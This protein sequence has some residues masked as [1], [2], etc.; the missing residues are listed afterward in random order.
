VR[1][2]LRRGG[3]GPAAELNALVGA[4]PGVRVVPMFGRWAYLAGGELF[5]CFPLRARD[6][7]LWIRL[8]PSA[9]ARA[10]AVP[11]VR[12]H[13]RFGRRG[14]IEYDVTGPREVRLAARWLRQAYESL[15]GREATG[16]PGG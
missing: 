5:G 10:L 7:D 13:R 4:W 14:W 2:S 11:G 15:P 9:Q 1:R 16:P 8:G 6:R 12:P 3:E